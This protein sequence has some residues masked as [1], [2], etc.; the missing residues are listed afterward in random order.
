MNNFWEILDNGIV[1][2]M[3]STIYLQTL[4][5]AKSFYLL[6]V[7]WTNSPCICV[8]NAGQN[9]G[10]H[11]RPGMRI[12]RKASKSSPPNKWRRV[13][14]TIAPGNTRCTNWFKIV[15]FSCKQDEQ[16]IIANKLKIAEPSIDIGFISTRKTRKVY[17]YWKCQIINLPFKPR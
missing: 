8:I 13:A 2:R 14:F 9:D 11:L 12:T 16:S 6:V 5:C 7:W 17:E 15:I 1:S 10:K 3:M 4:I